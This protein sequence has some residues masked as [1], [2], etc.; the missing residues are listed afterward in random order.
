MYDDLHMD[1]KGEYL[2]A[3]GNPISTALERVQSLSTRVLI[4]PNAAI[5]LHLLLR[6]NAQFIQCALH[7]MLYILH[8]LLDRFQKEVLV[9]AQELI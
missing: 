7:T 2:G 9:S 1:A 3:G 5:L 6:C 8:H 4:Y